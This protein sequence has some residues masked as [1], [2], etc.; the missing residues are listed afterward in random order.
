M[1]CR[2]IIFGL[3]MS[4]ASIT[5]TTAQ[6]NHSRTEIAAK[7][8]S[9]AYS[10]TD[11]QVYTISLALK[12]GRFYLGEIPAQLAGESLNFLDHETFLKLA[13][14]V[15][16]PEIIA[17]VRALPTVGGFVSVKALK[18][19]GLPISFDIEEMTLSFFPT[20]DQRPGVHVSLA[21]SETIVPEQLAPRAVYSGYMNVTAGAQYSTTNTGSKRGEFSQGFG[22]SSAVRVMNLVIE[23]EAATSN[24]V[25]MRQGTRA[26]YDDAENALRYIAG[27]VTP[28]TA[29]IQG[30]GS[31]FG[32]SIQKS[33]DKIQP[34][35]SV[36]PTGQRSF[37]LERPSDV[38]IV[39]NGQVVRRLQMQPGDHDISEL[40][41]RSGENVV[42][43]E[44][45]D[46]TGKRT[47]LNFSQFYDYALLM[48][49]I[50]DWG[51]S[52][53]YKSL[54]GLNRMHYYWSEPAATG[55]YRLGLTEDLTGTLHAQVDSRSAMAGIMA[56][57][58]LWLGRVA[59]EFA[60]SKDW[61]GD[62]GFATALTYS[63]ETLLRKWSI[64]GSFQL[65]AEY[66][67]AGFTSIF[68]TSEGLDGFSVNG[69]YS[70]ELPDDYTLSLSA[71]AAVGSAYTSDRLGG[72]ITVS[73]AVRPNVN[74]SLSLSRDHT[75]NLLTED[76]QPSW[77][78]MGRL[79]IRAGKDTEIAFTQDGL[80]GTSVLGVS[81]AGETDSGRYAIKADIEKMPSAVTGGDPESQVDLSAAYSDTRL[82]VS[83]SRSRRVYGLNRGVVNDVSMVSAGGAIAFADGQVAVGR[84]VTDSFAIVTAHESL[85]DASVRVKTGD[86]PARAASDLLGPALVSDIPSYSHSQLPLDVEGAP[87]GYDLG[88]GVIDVRPQY[89]SGYTIKVGSDYSVLAVGSLEAEGQPLSLLSGLAREDGVP[90][91]RKVALFTNRGGRFAVEGLKPGRW[92]IEML[93]D[94]AQCFQL[95]VPEKTVGIF[96]A[97]LLTQRCA[98]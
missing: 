40:P 34:Q 53:G 97:G 66:R 81:T 59:A 12:D 98:S 11:R 96:D 78:V 17:A 58:P 51:F 33:Y 31:F 69:F 20:A 9:T 82:D 37:R 36:R 41:L 6:E 5:A 89:K 30:G 13:A 75:T 64:P 26:V 60:V 49:G 61:N 10:M 67:S 56:I 73:K 38:D 88:T 42:V 44:I 52:A 24:G 57:S 55:Y 4:L 7:P 74:W 71:N 84:T 35:K 19:A 25:A 87:E 22:F 65:A 62:G 18:E 21:G 63:P 46:D 15:L 32:V 83:A 77:T 1:Q 16:K 2:S 94:T 54:S 92:R 72:G 29:G 91:P 3:A 86:A 76:Y 45:T 14:P 43:L 50:S 79:N 85:S 27:D 93:G 8:M 39:V 48:P 23:T 68:S 70:L 95:T 90:D 47:T 28:P 80:H